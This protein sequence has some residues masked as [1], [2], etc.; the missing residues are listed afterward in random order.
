MRL[1]IVFE[2]MIYLEFSVGSIVFIIL[3]ILT[4]IKI[5]FRRLNFK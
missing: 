2:I 4:F 3:I 5:D 1:F